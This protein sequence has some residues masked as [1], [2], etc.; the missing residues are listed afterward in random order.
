MVE[1]RVPAVK[2]GTASGPGVGT[3]VAVAGGSE[4]DGSA[5][6]ASEALTA[7]DGDA[8]GAP[9]RHPDRSTETSKNTFGAARRMRAA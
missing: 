7:A 3:G 2:V 4:L 5:L 9:K 1:T 6:A 8:L